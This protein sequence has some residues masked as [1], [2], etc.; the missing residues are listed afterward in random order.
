MA[1]QSSGLV[2]RGKEHFQNANLRL[3]VSDSAHA[4]V[5]SSSGP[6]V[7]TAP[8]SRRDPGSWAAPENPREGCTTR[9]GATQCTTKGFVVEEHVVSVRDFLSAAVEVLSMKGNQNIQYQPILQSI[10]ASTSKP[11]QDHKPAQVAPV[12][13]PQVEQVR[14]LVSPD[15]SITPTTRPT[16][17]PARRLSNAA[18]LTHQKYAQAEEAE[19]CAVQTRSRA[20]TSSKAGLTTS[21]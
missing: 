6:G 19:T 20:T 15:V 10:R 16:T 2:T 13:P 5:G 12:D 18:T 4:K 21:F 1:D 7:P 11:A 17:R 8:N 14:K 9:K 3:V